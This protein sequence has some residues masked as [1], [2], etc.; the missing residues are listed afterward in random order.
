MSNDDAETI[1]DRDDAMEVRNAVDRHPLKSDPSYRR[2]LETVA[3]EVRKTEPG[4]QYWLLNQG[5][6]VVETI[7]RAVNKDGWKLLY[8]EHAEAEKTY[9]YH[10][11]HISL[12][13]KSA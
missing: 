11:S 5:F 13:G 10:K 3:T 6:E 8:E 4:D 2:L 7:M 9:W 12:A 1:W